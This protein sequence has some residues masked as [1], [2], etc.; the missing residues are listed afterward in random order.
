MPSPAS[1]PL[2]VLH[3][4]CTPVRFKYFVSGGATNVFILRDMQEMLTREEGEKRKKEKIY[5][6]PPL[7][8][9]IWVSSYIYGAAKIYV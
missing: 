2:R 9:S 4:F 8:K 3:L 5:E 7:Q 6:A 1:L